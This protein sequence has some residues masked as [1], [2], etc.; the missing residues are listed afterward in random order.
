MNKKRIYLKNVDTV[1]GNVSY[2]YLD[3]TQ[4]LPVFPTKDKV[5]SH[6]YL[7]ALAHKG[8]EKRLE[9]SGVRKSTDYIQRLNEELEVI[10]PNGL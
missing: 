3:K 2:T 5:E 10:H 7:Y 6:I 9:N 8:L 4:S 1:F